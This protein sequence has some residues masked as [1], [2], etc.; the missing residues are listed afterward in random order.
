MPV[1]PDRLVVNEEKQ[2]LE[3]DR[4]G[5][6]P[7]RKWGPYL[8]ERQWGPVREDY[9]PHGTAWDY[10]PHDQAPQPGLPLGRGWPGRYQR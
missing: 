9:S 2:R 10:L 3:D 7:W 4:L 8:S 6:R 1:V 5:R